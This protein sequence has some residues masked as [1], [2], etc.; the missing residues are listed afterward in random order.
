MNILDSLTKTKISIESS[1]PMKTRKGKRS[2]DDD[3]SISFNDWLSSITERIN[4]TMHFSCDGQPEPLIFHI[5][6]VRNCFILK[7]IALHKY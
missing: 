7:L 6:L 3:N 5:P 4:E 1:S 2:F